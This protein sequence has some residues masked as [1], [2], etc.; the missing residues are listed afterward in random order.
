MRT[1]PPADTLDAMIADADPIRTRR[2][3][4]IVDS[5]G[6][7][8]T[9]ARDGEEALAILQR[10]PAP[11]LAVINVIMPKIEGLALMQHIAERRVEHIPTLVLCGVPA[12]RAAVAR[13]NLKDSETIDAASDDAAIREAIVRLIPA[14]RSAGPSLRE[15][16]ATSTGRDWFELRLERLAG[17]LA[18]STDAPTIAIRLKLGAHDGCVVRNSVTAAA[19]VEEWLRESPAIR[20]AVE[21]QD[22][23]VIPDLERHASITGQPNACL[24]PF[25]G[26][27]IVPLFNRAYALVGVACLL[28]TRPLALDAHVLQA[29]AAQA[30]AG[31]ADLELEFCQ[32][33][34]E[35]ERSLFQR[36]LGRRRDAAARQAATLAASQ[37]TDPVTS[38]LTR[39]AGEEALAREAARVRRNGS[40]LSVALFRVEP[41]DDSALTRVA[42][43]LKRM[44]RGT[45]VSVRWDGATLLAALPGVG[46]T[47]S[48]RFAERV[49][50]AVATL[51]NGSGAVRVSAG[52]SELLPP[53]PVEAAIDRAESA[54]ADADRA[55]HNTSRSYPA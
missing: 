31:A 29:F 11:A 23:V 25:C 34:R 12:L 10:R 13:L 50:S 53:E 41:A 4:A 38:L 5:L 18:A 33:A 24:A 28:D 47:G 8:V 27:A 46:L 48:R 19:A 49:R 32:E 52:T 21:S 15:C 17:E 51:G 16:G 36:E 1:S 43:V 3:R 45:D 20:Y 30:R 26:T 14:A 6:F 44:A 40:K 9:T 35:Q 22:L 42:G 55:G 39:R 54:A 7:Q 37:M 2:L